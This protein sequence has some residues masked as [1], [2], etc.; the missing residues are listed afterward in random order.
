MDT[1]LL[2]SAGQYRDQVVVNRV[3]RDPSNF[4]TTDTREYVTTLTAYVGPPSVS[5]DTS[6]S[7]QST[8]IN[9]TI[10]FRGQ[11]EVSFANTELV[12]NGRVLKPILPA[13][14]GGRYRD[15]GLEITCTDVTDKRGA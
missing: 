1:P 7:G 12:W 14:S 5:V 11:P 2:S 8:T 13:A 3:T 9:R 10:R 15:R 6:Q 4:G